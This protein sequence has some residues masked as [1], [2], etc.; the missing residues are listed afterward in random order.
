MKCSQPRATCHGS[1]G[2]GNG[3]GCHIQIVAAHRPACLCGR[4]I[5]GWP[6]VAAF[7]RGCAFLKKVLSQMQSLPC[8]EGSSEI[9]IS[10]CLFFSRFRL[11][12]LVS[13]ARW[14]DY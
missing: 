8:L 7:S 13:G 12:V 11:A 1:S 6:G 9:E 4:L 2:T 10:P 3:L 5:A 14:P